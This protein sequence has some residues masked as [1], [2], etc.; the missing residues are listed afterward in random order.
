[1][2]SLIFSLYKNAPSQAERIR[3]P[4]WRNKFPV[5]AVAY[6]ISVVVVVVGAGGDA[7]FHGIYVYIH[8]RIFL[9]CHG[10][11]RRVSRVLSV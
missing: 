9:S 4:Y 6:R 3:P 8:I 7:A 10:L 1:M 2:K 11:L 5:S